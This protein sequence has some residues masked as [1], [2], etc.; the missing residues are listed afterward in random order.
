MNY[1]YIVVGAGS[2]G[3]AVASRLSENGKYR[4]A[5]LE[6]GGK[7]GHVWQKI[8]LGVG[9][10]LTDPKFVWQYWM[11]QQESLAGQP[12]Y[13]PCGKGLGGSS[14][15]NG[16]VFVRGEPSRYDL[17]RDEGNDGWGFED[18]LPFFKKLEDRIDSK[19]DPSY[20]GVG[21]PIA[22]SDTTQRDEIS[23]GFIQA[24]QEWGTPYNPDINGSSAEGVSWMQFSIRNGVRCSTAKGYLTPAI[25]RGNLDVHTNSPVEKILFDGKRANGVVINSNGEQRKLVARREVVLSAGPI[26][27]PKLLELSGVGNGE[28]LSRHGINVVHDLPG[29]GEN[30]QDHLQSRINYRVNRHVTVNDVMNNKL[31]AARTLLKYLFT[32]KGLMATSSANCIALVKST[33]S[34]PVPDIK[35]QLTLYSAPDRYISSQENKSV[36]DPFPGIGLGQIQLYPESRGSIHIQSTNPLDDPFMDPRFLDHPRDVEL[37]I[38]GMEIMREISR[39]PGL[40]EYLVEESLPGPQCDSEAAMRRYVNESGQ[41]S[42]HPMGSCRMGQGEMDVVNARLQ[43]HGM[44]GLRVVDS[45]IMPSFTSSNI[46]IPTIAIAEKGAAMIL[47]DAV[48]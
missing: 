36:A 24:C 21:G 28:I 38:R 15:V 23:H 5:L 22:C 31:T 4:V 11:G 18:L 39:Q 43:V 40:S 37:T 33:P 19:V 42:W 41:T 29:V 20:R 3:C 30:F 6:A 14:S 44:S 34:V 13:N 2:A 8:P 48:A 16:M 7:D 35:V 47:E 12:I 27:S 45:S 25:K 1:D 46:N 10:M 17:W 9:K 26:I 32:R